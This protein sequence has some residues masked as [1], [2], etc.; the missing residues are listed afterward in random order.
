MSIAKLEPHAA[1]RD[2][3]SDLAVVIVTWNVR[4][5]ALDALRTLTD[6]L[7]AS[8][9]EAAVWVVDNAST[10]GTAEAVRAAFPAVRVIASSNNLG[11]AGGNNLALRELGFDDASSA[12]PAAA[13]LLNPD[14]RVQRGAVRTL[15]DA[16]RTR[17]RAGLVGA[18]LTYADGSF[19]HSA[20]RFP[21][22]GQIIVELLRVP[23][24]LHESRFN[25]RYP[26][27]WYAHGAPFPVDHTLGATMMVRREAIQQVGL[28]DE[29]FY[30]YCE[31]IDWQ[32][33]LRA[34]GWEVYCVPAAHVTHLA[35]QST[36]QVHAASLVNLW[37]S[38]LRL[39]EKH[40]PRYKVALARW[41]IRV[42][43]QRQ[44]RLAA[45]RFAAGEIS[46]A[47]RD[48]LVEAYRTIRAL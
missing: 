29:G 33:R 2:S 42:G 22:L 25:G 9:L 43:M 17:P 23:G 30:M 8:G 5:L 41:L 39:Y 20:F 13:F 32:M 35:G 28:L 3:R 36:G 21:G 6:D 27:D 48:A 4:D 11:F 18:R 37:R 12:A 31:E 19:Q 44:A 16:L 24:R 15:Y 26:R 14:T 47:E 34:A 10:D 46:A 40:Y 1:G 7:A 45:A 38:R